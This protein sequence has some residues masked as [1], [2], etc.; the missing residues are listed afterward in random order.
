MT[1]PERIAEVAATF[2]VALVD[3]PTGRELSTL[4]PDARA[5]LSV[6]WIELDQAGHL[7]DWRKQH[8]S[9]VFDHDEEPDL[10]IGTTLLG[11][12]LKGSKWI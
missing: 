9:T 1:Q 12:F 7:D 3:S 4:G 10:L 2:V 5:A 6:L 11:T 8:W